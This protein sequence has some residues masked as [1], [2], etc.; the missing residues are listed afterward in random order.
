MKPGYV[1]QKKS[2]TIL[3]CFRSKQPPF[4]TTH[5]PKKWLNSYLIQAKIIF[6]FALG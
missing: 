6:D 1:G 3:S 2:N 5:N 4:P